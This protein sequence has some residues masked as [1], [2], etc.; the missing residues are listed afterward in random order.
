MGKSVTSM[1]SLRASL[2]FHLEQQASSKFYA[3]IGQKNFAAAIEK[4]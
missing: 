3:V 4:F 2:F 1:Q